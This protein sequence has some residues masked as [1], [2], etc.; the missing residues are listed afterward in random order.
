MDNLVLRKIEVSDKKYFSKWWRDQELVTLTSGASKPISDRQVDKYFLAMLA[1]KQEYHFMVLAEKKVIGHVSLARR[2]SHWQETQI[3]I[4]EKEYWDQGFGTRGVQLLLKKAK[5]LGMRKM[6][7]EVRPTNARA[8][9]AYAKCGF[10]A[11]GIKGYPKNKYL[12]ETLRMELT[13]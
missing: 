2:A 4:G 1:S 8:I 5:R 6:Y 7:L 10:V 3:V 11:V 12:P 13:Y 9:A